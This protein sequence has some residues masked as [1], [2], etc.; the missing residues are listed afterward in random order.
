MNYPT[1]HAGLVLACLMTLGV[2]TMG[3]DNSSNT[4][5]TAPPTTREASATDHEHDA[6]E[7]AAQLA[8]LSP[9]DRA[10]ADKQKVCP[11]SDEPLGSMGVP[12]KA[13]ANGHELFLCCEAC[14]DALNKEP[15]KYVA[16][17]PD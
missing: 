10:A 2:W 11:V 7:I 14:Q 15:E 1:A 4:T 3:C 9:E 12:V 5:S 13:T 17:L 6:A 8:Q 16:K